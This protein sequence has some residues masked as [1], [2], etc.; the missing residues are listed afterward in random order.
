MNLGGPSAARLA[1]RRG[2]VFWS[3]PVPSGGPLTMVES[4]DTASSLMR[5]A[6]S[7]CHFSKT[8][9]STP[10]LAQRFMRV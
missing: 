1:D 5:T 9:A 6:C 3:A 8:L 4:S 2:S 7:R 10:L